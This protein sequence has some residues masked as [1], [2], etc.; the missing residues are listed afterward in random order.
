[1]AN[2]KWF[3]KAVNSKPPYS[4]GGWKKT[5]APTTRRREALSS[6]PKSWSLSRRRLSA[7]R[8]LIALANVTKDQPTKTKAR[9]DAK[10]FFRK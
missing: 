3:Q 10:Y 9:A 2:K 6:R 5:Q 8:A 4:L 7:G 1:M